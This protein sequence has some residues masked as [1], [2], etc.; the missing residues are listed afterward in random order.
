MDGV[1]FN[2]SQTSLIQ[3]PGGKVGI[4]TIPESVTNIWAFAFYACNGLT[5]VTIGNGITSIGVYAFAYCTSL[6]A[7]YFQGNAP[8][9]DG[10]VLY[11]DNN[12][13][14]YYLPGTTGWSSTFGGRPTV[15]WLPEV[16]TS[17]ADF[18]VRTNRFGFTI[19]WAKDR[20][21]VVEAS[22]GLGN[23]VWTPVST[24]TLSGGLSYFSDPQW[25]NHPTRFYRVV[26]VVP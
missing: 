4:Y 11:D 3:Y 1:L 25:T 8:N 17:D 20:V 24:N 10:G 6:T 19:R 13:T 22:P 18:G 21:V 5:S 12:A 7:V 16:R 9:V 15:L 14:V 23:P 26:S 2:K